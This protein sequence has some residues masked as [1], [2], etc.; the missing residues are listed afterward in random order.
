MHRFV[1]SKLSTIPG[2]SR[3]VLGGYNLRNPV[4]LWIFIDDNAMSETCL[5]QE[6]QELNKGVSSQ[7]IVLTIVT[8]G[9]LRLMQAIVFLSK[10]HL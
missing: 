6:S 8:L 9:S 10:S 3:V 4:L 7:T 1:N 2:I 5:A